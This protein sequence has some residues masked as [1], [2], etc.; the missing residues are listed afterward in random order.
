LV[1]ERRDVPAVVLAR[2]MVRNAARSRSR[3][4]RLL[5]IGWCGNPCKIFCMVQVVLRML[6]VE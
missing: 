6:S 2:A 5:P 4:E 3:W 1:W